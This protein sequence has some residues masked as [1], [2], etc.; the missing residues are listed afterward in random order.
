MTIIIKR[1]E[2]RIALLYINAH[3]SISFKLNGHA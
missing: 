3:D 1:D 2:S